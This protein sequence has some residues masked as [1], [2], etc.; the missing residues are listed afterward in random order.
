LVISYLLSDFGRESL[1]PLNNNV[2][3]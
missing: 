2:N 3:W 1:G